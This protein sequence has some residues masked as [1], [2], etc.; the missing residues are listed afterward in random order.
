MREKSLKNKIIW[1][2]YSNLNAFIWMEYI[3]FTKSC[4]FKKIL[5]FLIWNKFLLGVS[6]EIY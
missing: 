2:I 6:S 1:H 5:C 4:G 3:V